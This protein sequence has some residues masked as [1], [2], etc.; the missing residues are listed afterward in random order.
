MYER[1]LA[2]NI[3][4]VRISM[5]HQTTDQKAPSTLFR[6]DNQT[7]YLPLRID[8]STVRYLLKPSLEK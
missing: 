5:S 1:M 8:E 2:P 6:R 7:K 3:Y 4:T